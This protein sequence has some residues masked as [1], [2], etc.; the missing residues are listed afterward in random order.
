MTALVL[1]CAF[2]GYSFPVMQFATAVFDRHMSW[3]G[4]A[5][6]DGS[7]KLASRALFNAVRFG[8]AA[9][10]YGLLTVRRQRRFS[11]DEFAGGIVVGA[12]FATGMLLQVT[13]LRWTL[14]SISSFLTALAVV[15]APL[16]QSAILRRPLDRPTWLAVSLAI[17]GMTVLSWPSPNATARH[18]LTMTPPVAHL[19]EIFTVVAS[20]LFTGQILAVDHFGRRADGV[21]LTLVMLATTSILS[22]VMGAVIGGPSPFGHT[23]WHGLVRDPHVLWTMSSLVVISSVM[24]L[25]LMNTYQPRVSPAIASVIYCTEPLFGTL[26]SVLAATERLTVTT[27]AGGATV[28]TSVLVVAL[29]ARNPL[30]PSEG[31]LGQ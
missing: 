4:A 2:W 13:G 8:L 5:G 23:Q 31:H 9:S 20:M 19:G 24:A 6:D 10:L 28:L 1:C 16:A 30:L 12:F 3:A 27:V 29:A 21:R 15:F 17:V 14:P 11:R 26:F 7:H 18:T 25:H 22:L